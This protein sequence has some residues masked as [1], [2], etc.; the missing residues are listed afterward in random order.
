[1]RNIVEMYSALYK[2]TIDFYV[3]SLYLQTDRL[4]DEKTDD[5]MTTIA[6]IIFFE[7]ARQEG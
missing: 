7:K 4:M 2:C 6:R 3:T 1:M 5:I